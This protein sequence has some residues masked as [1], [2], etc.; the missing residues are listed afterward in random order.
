[1]T[2]GGEK[3]WGR[4]NHAAKLNTRMPGTVGTGTLGTSADGG[5]ANMVVP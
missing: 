5:E 4:S 3:L 2:S 1:M